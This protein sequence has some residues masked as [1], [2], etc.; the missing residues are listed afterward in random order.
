MKLAALL[1]V[2]RPGPELGA[3]MRALRAQSRP[4]DEIWVAETGPSRD[5]AD[6]VTGLGGRYVEVEPDA[7]DHAGTRTRLAKLANADRLLLVSQD[8]T[9]LQADTVE[10]LVAS[11]DHGV[12]AAYGRQLAGPESHPFTAFKRAF[13]YPATSREW[14]IADRDREGFDALAFSNAYAVYRTDALAAVGWFG[15]RRLMCED[16]STAASLLLGGQRLAYVADATVVH[17]QDHSL[18]A[19]LRRYFDIGAVHCMDPRIVTEFG[20]PR[21]KGVRFTRAGAASLWR[22]HPGRLPDFALW[23]ALKW[24]AYGLGRRC[25]RLPR[26]VAAKLSGLP[27]WWRRETDQDRG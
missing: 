11:L 27:G 19:E 18:E 8:V 2:L 6:L 21:V 14:S 10:R 25:D 1:P 24:V 16:V 22:S 3:L 26:G 13:L 12:A 7:F 15:E 20:T 17:P 5:T 4:P 23:C 9:I